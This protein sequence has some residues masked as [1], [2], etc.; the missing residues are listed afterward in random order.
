MGV[1][2]ILPDGSQ[3]KCWNCEMVTK[4]VGDSVPDFGL[5]EY[6]VLLREGGYVR[7]KNGVI[8]EIKE[9]SNIDYYPEDF[10]GV[11]CFDKWGSPVYSRDDLVGQFQV[12]GMDDPYYF[13][14]K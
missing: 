4:K 12:A 14:G 8:T 13:G 3:V 7:V 2:D 1:Y 10:E 11:P 5:E 9:N 6:I